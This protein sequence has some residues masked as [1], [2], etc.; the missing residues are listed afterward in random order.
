MRDAVVSS[1][2]AVVQGWHH[3]ACVAVSNSE[4]SHL[5]EFGGE[6]CLEKLF[7]SDVPCALF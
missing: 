5:V 6:K 1:C 7:I 2:R 4:M 3:C